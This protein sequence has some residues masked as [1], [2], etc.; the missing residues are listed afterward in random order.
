[1]RFGYRIGLMAAFRGGDKKAGEFGV[2]ASGAVTDF[3][4]RIRD[5]EAAG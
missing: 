2:A 5:C 1:M 4:C 3:K